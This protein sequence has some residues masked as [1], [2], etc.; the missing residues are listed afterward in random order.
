M[1]EDTTELN[2]CE[3]KENPMNVLSI[4]SFTHDERVP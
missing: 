2:K 1:I 3:K 4:F